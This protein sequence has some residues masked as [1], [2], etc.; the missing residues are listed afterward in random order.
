[1]THCS[2]GGRVIHVQGQVRVDVPYGRG[3]MSPETGAVTHPP[4]DRILP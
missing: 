3:Y 4:F 2:G 1:M